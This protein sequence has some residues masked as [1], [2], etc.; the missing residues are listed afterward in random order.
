MTL[1]RIVAAISGP[2]GLGLTLGLIALLVGREIAGSIGG[3]GARRWRRGL[4]LGIAPL[5]AVFAVVVTL[6]LLGPIGAVLGAGGDT[7]TEASAS[8]PP[9]A[10]VGATATVPAPPQATASVAP[11]IASAA[12]AALTPTVIAPRASPNTAPA[13]ST[14]SA[15]PD[16]NAL[17]ALV[18]AE[19]SDVRRG[20]VETTIDYGGGNMAVSTVTFDLGDGSQP[21]RLLITTTYQGATGSRTVRR[22]TIGSQ[23][24]QRGAEATWVRQATPDDVRAQVAEVLPQPGTNAIAVAFLPARIATLRWYE[25]ARDADITLQVDAATGVPQEERRAIRSG[26]PTLT[27]RYPNW[28]G[29]VDIPN[30]AP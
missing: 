23:T 27:V 28:N 2:W 22:L 30:L 19:R 14:P 25:A 21:A 12:P 15:T 4:S 3:N 13:A 9:I 5:L 18:R 20:T 10:I 7:A 16:G 6:R 17:V 8:A 29:P 1:D 11:P 26:G 24:W